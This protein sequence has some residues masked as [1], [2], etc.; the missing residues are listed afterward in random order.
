VLVTG[1]R[2][3]SPTLAIFGDR[4]VQVDWRTSVRIYKE[5]FKKA[6]NRDLTIKIYAGAGHNLYR[7]SVP[8]MDSGSSSSS[9]FVDGY[10]DLMVGWLRTRGFAQQP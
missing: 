10:L 7:T 2:K 4:D 9:T 5:S 8:H 3:S 6:R 1:H